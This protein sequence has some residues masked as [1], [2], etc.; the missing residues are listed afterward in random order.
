MLVTR[1]HYKCHPQD[2]SH[3]NTTILQCNNFAWS[4]LLHQPTYLQYLYLE[5][6]HNAESS[7]R[8]LLEKQEHEHGEYSK[9][10]NKQTNKPNKSPK[11]KKDKDK[12]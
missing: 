4:F 11:D 12:I 10:S 2:V 7:R 3:I 6:T 1:D 8:K 5:H 9:Q